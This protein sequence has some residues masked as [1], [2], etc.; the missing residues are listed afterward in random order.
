MVRAC[1]QKARASMWKAGLLALMVGLA[2]VGSAHA[3]DFFGLFG[4]GETAPE[5][6]ADALPYDL[7]IDVVGDDATIR[8]AIQDISTLQQLRGDAPPDAGALARRAQGDILPVIDALWG[9]GYYNAT[10]TIDVAGVTMRIGVDRVDEAAAAAAGFRDRERVPVSIIVDPARRFA[11]RDLTIVDAATGRNLGAELPE[12]VIALQ[13]GDPASAARILSAQARIVDHYREQSRPFAD[14]ASIDPVVHHPDEVM[15]LTI[16]VS[17]GPVAGI[18]RI[19][20]SGND[21][22]DERVIRSFIYT[23][24]SDPYSPQALAGIRTSLTRIEALSSVRIRQGEQLDADGNLPLD[25]EVSE[26]LPRAFGISAQFSTTDGPSTRVYWTHR[27]LFGGAERLR[28]EASAFYLT[29]GGGAL[30]DR[31][32][33]F[34]DDLGGRVSASF[35]KPALWGTRNDFLADARIERDRADGFDT[36]LVNF[37]TGIRHRFSDTF[38]IQAG[39]EFERGQTK[40]AVRKRDYRLVGLPLTLSFDS[41]DNRLEPTEGW[42]INAGVTPYLGALGSSLNMVQTRFDAAT[43][44]ALDDRARYILAARVGF[45][46]LVGAELENIPANRRF[47]AGGGGSVRGYAFRSLSPMRAG[48]PIGG[49]SLI[50][51]SLEARI[52]ITDTI[53]IVPFIDA[54]GAF[55]ESYPDFGERLRFA[56]GLGLRYYTGIGPIRLDVAFPL[57]KEAGQRGYGVY[58]GIGQAF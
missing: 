25:V 44:F 40:D 46:S 9:L 42:R 37:T 55:R 52:R 43:Y 57:Q 2:P 39:V 34:V 51:G 6:S 5:P 17:P 56:A 22:V 10:V 7:T 24:P 53:G 8:T 20:V 12:D 18:G 49:R 16:S 50:E 23:E 47:F 15:D 31:N 21:N 48:R 11:I 36:R 1:G 28:L 26:R 35:M 30:F 41:S 27:N 4:R 58:L 54:G 45:G 3:F 14:I 33:N 32:R 19:S 38:N 13:P 29:E